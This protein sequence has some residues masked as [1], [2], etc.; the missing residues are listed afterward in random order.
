[1]L[2]FIKFGGSAIT[3]KQGQEAPDMPVIQALAADVQA[4]LAVRS[5]NTLLL[6]HGSG[7]FGHSYA[8]QYGIHRGLDASANWMGFALTAAAAL[9][10]NRIIVDALLAA[11]VPALSLQPSASLASAAGKLVNWQIEPICRALDHKLVPVI[12]GDVAFDTMQ[13]SAII[14]TEALFTHVALNTPLRPARIVLVGENA[15]YTADPHRHTGAE[16]IPLITEK[17]I[18][19]VLHGTESSHAVDVTGG[20][21]SKLELMWQLVQ[22]IP[23]L[24]IHLIGPTSGLLARVLQGEAAGEG[25]VIRRA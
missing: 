22:A 9:R 25:T 6:G 7:S 2:T 13:G 5:D 11:G 12:H 14:S 1:M 3:D 20:M 21:R 19:L 4:A 15:V 24:E 17:N 8:A 18:G 16:P 23:Q 10:L